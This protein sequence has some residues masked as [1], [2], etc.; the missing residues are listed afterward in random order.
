[1]LRVFCHTGG[2]ITVIGCVFHHGVLRCMSRELTGTKQSNGTAKICTSLNSPYIRPIL[3]S[4]T[5]QMKRFCN[6]FFAP[7][8]V[9]RITDSALL[10]LRV[11]L[12]ATILFN[13]GIGKIKGF[14]TMSS[15][16]PDLLGIGSP[17][18]LVLVIFAEAVCGALLIPGVMTRF[19][20]L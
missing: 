1:M 17:A 3:E 16:F 20:A 7:S 5:K 15:G 11:W 8:A 18:T 9:S 2:R 13:H 19:A 12:G 14:D 10:L 4:T 6:S